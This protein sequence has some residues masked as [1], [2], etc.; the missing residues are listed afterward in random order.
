MNLVLCGMMGCGKTTVGKRLAA[1]TNRQWYDT[2][3]VIVEQHGAISEIFARFGEAY[4]REIETQTVKQLA[5]QDNLVLSV[6][7]GLVL[8]QE[9]V[10]ILRERCKIIFLQ[11]EVS[12]LESRLQSDT[13]RPLL[14]GGDMSLRERLST[15]L[16]KRT[17]AYKNAADYIVQVDEKSVDD[18]VQEILALIK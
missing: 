15:L 18:I 4:F 10:A 9:N 14:Q 11:A 5:A 16:E 1:L 2:D 3:D 7:G 6:G 13:T 12:T 8:K 17:D